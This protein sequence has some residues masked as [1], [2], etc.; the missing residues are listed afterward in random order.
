MNYLKRYLYEG[1]DD[2]FIEAMDM[3]GAIW[4]DSYGTYFRTD[5]GYTEAF[6]VPIIEDERVLMVTVD[7][8]KPFVSMRGDHAW[9]PVRFMNAGAAIALINAACKLF[10]ARRLFDS[11]ADALRRFDICAR[12]LADAEGTD[13]SAY[14]RVFGI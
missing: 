9:C 3:M 10:D 5:K 14:Y 2:A 4:V 1:I 8:E 7:H 11:E 12:L 6:C 13:P